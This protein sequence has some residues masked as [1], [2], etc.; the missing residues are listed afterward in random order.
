VYIYIF[1]RVLREE[2]GEEK[3]VTKGEESK[4]DELPSRDGR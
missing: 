4:E 2:G 1:R 3:Q